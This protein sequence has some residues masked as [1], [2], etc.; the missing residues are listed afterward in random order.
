MSL[1]F[2][3]DTAVTDIK[4]LPSYSSQWQHRLWTSSWP[5]QDVSWTITRFLA[6]AQVIDIN[7]VSGGIKYHRSLSKRFNPENEPFFISDTLLLL[8]V[9]V[10][11]CWTGPALP[12][13]LPWPSSFSLWTA[14]HLCILLLPKEQAVQGAPCHRLVLLAKR[15]RWPSMQEWL[16]QPGGGL[17]L[18]V[19][20][21]L[22]L[23]TNTCCHSCHCFPPPCMSLHPAIFFFFETCCFQGRQNKLSKV[24]PPKFSIPLSVQ[25]TDH[26]PWHLTTNPRVTE[27]EKNI[28]LIGKESSGLLWKT[29]AVLQSNILLWI[30]FILYFCVE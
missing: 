28:L 30:Q 26:I 18:P 9:K 25:W 11:S 1:T 22:A 17:V 12:V 21:G 15:P 19:A 29:H 13:C 8:R 24:K 2:R 4:Q 5:L 3:Y 14:S 10:M 16:T 6:A 20:W 23:F 7:T 27:V